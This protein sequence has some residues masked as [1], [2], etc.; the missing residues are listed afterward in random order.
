MAC[1]LDGVSCSRTRVTA[2]C[3]DCQDFQQAMADPAGLLT[4]CKGDRQKEEKVILFLEAVVD[5]PELRDRSDGPVICERIKRTLS[6]HRIRGRDT[7]GRLPFWGP[8][9]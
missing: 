2:R 5:W 9:S 8:T 6:S 7:T 4:D 3:L 1:I